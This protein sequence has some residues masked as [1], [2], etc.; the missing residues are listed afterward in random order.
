MQFSIILCLFGHIYTNPNPITSP[1]LHYAL[2]SSTPMQVKFLDIIEDE[3][4]LVVSQRLAMQA[5]APQ[6]K[7]GELLTAT[8]TGLR[9][10]GVF[11]ELPGGQNGLLHISQISLERIEKLDTIFSVGE[12][13]K[14]VVIEHDISLGR[15]ALATRML[16]EK[17]GDMI[18]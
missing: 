13:V 16:E 6:L 17:P 12:V 14:V 18:R 15:V 10:Y 1:P 2:H 8:V 5:N 7:R 11:V 9:P 4:K 3:G